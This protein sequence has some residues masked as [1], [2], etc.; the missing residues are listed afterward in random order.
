[1][2]REPSAADRSWTSPAADGALPS[3]AGNDRPPHSNGGT[4]ISTTSRLRSIAPF[5]ALLAL[6]IAVGALPSTEARASAGGPKRT[7]QQ[8]VAPGITHEAYTWTTG[9]GSQRVNVLRFRLDDARVELRPELAD[10]EIPGTEV[11]ADTVLRLG[12]QAIGAVNGG[13]WNSNPTGDPRGL[14]VA[15]STYVSEPTNPSEQSQ[16]EVPR[17][18][19]TINSDGT[20]GVGRP[21]YRGE[22]WLP[23]GVEAPVSAIN[24]RPVRLDPAIDC[25]GQELPCGEIIAFTSAYG[26]SSDNGGIKGVELVI[27]DAR[28]HL[29]P[30]TFQR[31]LR[32]ATV[33]PAGGPIGPDDVVI[34]GTGAWRSIFD[35]FE[36][37]Q[38][39][40]FNFQL[41]DVFWP[42]AE[43]ALGAGPLLLQGNA[44]T[45]RRDWEDEGFDT[46]HNFRAHPRT[47][48]GFTE[49][50]EALLLTV[51]GRQSG[52]STGITTEET[53]HLMQLLGV[54]DAVMLDGG[55]STQMAV[56]GRNVNRPSE[57]RA[58]ADSLVLYSTVE[59]PKVERLEGSDRYATAAQSAIAG[60]PDGSENVLIAS[61]ADFP[62]GLAGGPLGARRKAPLLLT[63]SSS[64]PGATEA[65]LGALDPDVIYLL[66]GPAAVSETIERNL[67]ARGYD[68]AR[69]WGPTRIETAAAIAGAV[70]APSGRAFLASGAAFPDALSATV[71]ASLADAPL[72][73]TAPHELSPATLTKLKELNVKEVLIAGGVAAVHEA[74]RTALRDQG[75]RVVRIAGADRYATSREL[76]EWAEA[77]LAFRPRSAAFAS[78]IDF[79]DALSGGPF[80]Y[81]RAMPLLLTHPYD[82]S[83]ATG[84]DS[85]V[86]THGL[87]DATILGGRA[88]VRSWVAYQLQAE[89]DR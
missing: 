26:P 3:A 34:V 4:T 46:K 89:I 9:A 72:L 50:G 2:D 69:L 28:P 8:A 38:T 63:R 48:I 36:A 76:V 6:V 84:V 62:D 29:H 35:G 73:L 65:A 12:P 1:M 58:V 5:S 14:V 88:A 56:D 70:G 31:N 47:A 23:N 77:N 17:G 21:S 19:F 42:D 49:D 59:T 22:V 64:L 83:R 66:G 67:R 68:V 87:R 57:T 16:A 51:D 15:G 54:V 20:W 78:G 32:I 44:R 40:A 61:G 18:A 81:R 52:W 7:A 80:A 11:V 43:S 10:G 37:G 86:R 25:K 60:W 24:R 27:Q 85:W 79:P 33:R 30:F 82:L 41:G 45:A 13:F 74:V 39:V 55:G 75:F 53:Q 71:P